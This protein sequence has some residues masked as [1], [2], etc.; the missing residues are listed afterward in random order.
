MKLYYG[1][2]A[3]NPRRVR[4]YLAEKGITDVEQVKVDM[5]AEEHRTEEFRRDKN[6]LAL[7]PVLELD[8]GQMLTESMAIIEY[9]EEL[10]PDPPLIGRDPWQRARTREADRIADLGLMMAA[11]LVWV[12]S[13]PYFAKRVNQKPDVAAFG[14]ERL[15]EYFARIDGML[16]ERPWLAGDEFTVADITTLCAIDF[17]HA[18]GVKVDPDQ[19]PNVAR[20]L[21]VI[22]Q[23]P[24]CMIKRKKA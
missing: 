1:S 18:G 2:F 24:S 23:R 8:D 3:P 12:S 6:A 4:I 9:L 5:M 16:A 19:Y 17:A 11:S 15:A 22:R 7:L 14:R 10:H 20:W 21:E 13:S